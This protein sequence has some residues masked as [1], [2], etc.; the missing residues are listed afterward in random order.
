MN[1]IP[2]CGSKEEERKKLRKKRG[3]MEKEGRRR[4]EVRGKERGERHSRYN[5]P[6]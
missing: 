5:I 2:I 4:W 3:R 1:N 6:R